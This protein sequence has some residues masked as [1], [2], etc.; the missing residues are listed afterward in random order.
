MLERRPYKTYPKFEHHIW[1]FVV[2]N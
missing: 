1:C 2:E